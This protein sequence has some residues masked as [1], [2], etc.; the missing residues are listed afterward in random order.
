MV[1][2]KDEPIK[3]STERA[4]KFFRRLADDPFLA[5]VVD[6]EGELSIYIKGLEPAHLERIRGVLRAIMEGRE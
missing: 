2:P 1:N 5:I 6:D 4:Q 3:L